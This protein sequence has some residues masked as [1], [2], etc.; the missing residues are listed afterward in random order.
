MGQIAFDGIWSARG[1]CG[2]W[3]VNGS[4]SG[5]GVKLNAAFRHSDVSSPL[6]DSV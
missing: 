1:I 5:S 2:L 4:S 6:G 3:S